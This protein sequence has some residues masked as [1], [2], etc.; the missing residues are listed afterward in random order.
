MRDDAWGPAGGVACQGRDDADRRSADVLPAR[1]AN[2][3]LPAGLPACL[4]AAC[5][6]VSA[7]VHAPGVPDAS[8]NASESCTRRMRRLT[9]LIAQNEALASQVKARDAEIATLTHSVN[10]LQ[11]RLGDAVTVLADKE[12]LEEQV[13]RQ[14]DAINGQAGRIA[15]LQEALVERTTQLEELRATNSELVL[16]SSRTKEHDILFGE[17]WIIET[18][19]HR[20]HGTRPRAREGNV[21]VAMH[22]APAIPAAMVSV[23]DTRG[24]MRL[25]WA[26]PRA[27]QGRKAGLQPG[28]TKCARV[29][30]PGAIAG[31]LVMLGGH[32]DSA[33]G[34]EVCH[35]DLASMTWHQRPTARQQWTSVQA[36]AAVLSRT[37]VC[38]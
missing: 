32:G 12:R 23:C 2:P 38:S 24:A 36:S 33:L 37:K 16:Q 22:G 25:M 9:A 4:P 3:V 29:N 35:L 1:L 21:L 13:V 17:P 31:M 30:Q 19:H 5:P 8:A 6:A 7:V 20:L 14:L 18:S 26:D 28:S 27:L 10:T 15:A 34:Q 11:T